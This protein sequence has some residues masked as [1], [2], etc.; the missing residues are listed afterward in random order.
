[1]ENFVPYMGKAKD[2][3]EILDAI[4][5]VI[6][7]IQKDRPAK[8]LYNY[9]MELRN[10]KVLNVCQA[11]RLHELTRVHIKKNNLWNRLFKDKR[12]LKSSEYY[13]GYYWRPNDMDS[14]LNFLKY[15]KEQY[16]KINKQY[17]K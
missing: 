3:K 9:F 11:N 10:S 15:I 14:R 8:G 4:D 6:N 1:M 2:V 16:E 7:N 17:L 12:C 13:Y 5:I